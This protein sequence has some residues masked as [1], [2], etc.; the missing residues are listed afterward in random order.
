[1]Y[2][3]RDSSALAADACL[4]VHDYTKGI[5]AFNLDQK[6]LMMVNGEGGQS[7]IASVRN[8]D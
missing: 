3:P 4:V 8:Q 5:N 2:V 7:A 6:G 1:V